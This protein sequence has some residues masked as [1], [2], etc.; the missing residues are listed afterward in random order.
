[1]DGIFPRPED[2]LQ[3]QADKQIL[4]NKFKSY[5][6]A[7]K[8]NQELNEQHIQTLT[9]FYEHLA[10]YSAGAI[11]F[12]T[13]IIG[14]VLPDNTSSLSSNKFLLPNIVYLYL[15]WLGFG[16]SFISAV[17]SKRVYAF[18]L[19]YTGFANYT[20]RYGEYVNQRISFIEKYKENVVFESG[21]EQGTLQIDKSNIEKLN[22]GHETNEKKSKEY[23]KYY[24]WLTNTALVGAGVGVVALLIFAF[25]LT[26]TIVFL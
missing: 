21:D 9:K 3:Q 19:S 16:T 11:T 17:V 24:I 20:K 25:L 26:Q 15:S 18:Y 22:L 8:Q 5:D 12:T 14:F 2:I 13:T 6:L 4:D 10:L 7:G 1:M 23:Y